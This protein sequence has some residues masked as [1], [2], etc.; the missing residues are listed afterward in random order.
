MENNKE[1]WDPDLDDKIESL[2]PDMRLKIKEYLGYRAEVLG[3]DTGVLEMWGKSRGKEMYRTREEEMDPG[4]GVGSLKSKLQK[5]STPKRVVGVTRPIHSQRRGREFHRVQ[6]VY[7][8]HF[9][10]RTTE[11]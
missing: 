6:D 2:V 5:W 8:N 4:E 10:D 7:G 11:H 3:G 1:S 9:E